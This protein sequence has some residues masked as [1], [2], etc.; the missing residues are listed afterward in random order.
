MHASYFSNFGIENEFSALIFAYF[1]PLKG[2]KDIGQPLLS[3]GICAF[4]SR[5]VSRSTVHLHNV[6]DPM[7][8]LD[9]AYFVETE[10]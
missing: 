6:R 2:F 5:Q 8:Y 4:F 9:I 10:N 7:V 1:P 3:L